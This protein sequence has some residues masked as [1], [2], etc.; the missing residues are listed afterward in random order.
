MMITQDN[1]KPLY[2]VMRLIKGATARYANQILKRT[3]NNFWQRDNYN[4]Y[5][6]NGTELNN[7]INYIVQNPVKAGLVENWQDFPFVYV[8]KN[9]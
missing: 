3:D 6:R 2:E 5:V 9:T 7:I 8:A 1:Y 4:H